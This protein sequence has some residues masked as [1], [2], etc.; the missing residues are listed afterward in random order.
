MAE[1]N[2]G[3]AVSITTAHPDGARNATFLKVLRDHDGI[4]EYAVRLDT[5]AEISAE[6]WR[7]T[8]EERTLAEYRAAMAINSNASFYKGETE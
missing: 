1:F 6:P 8:R 2:P 5:G 4:D 7:V 3:D